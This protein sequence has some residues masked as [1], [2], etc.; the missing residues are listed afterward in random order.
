MADTV[1]YMSQEWRDEAEKRLW[2]LFEA[3]RMTDQQGH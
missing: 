3:T 1:A 2:F